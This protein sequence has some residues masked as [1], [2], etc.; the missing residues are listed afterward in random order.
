MPDGEVAS[1]RWTPVGDNGLIAAGA[2]EADAP[3]GYRLLS[4]HDPAEPSPNFVD[5]DN[6]YIFP[7][8][9]AVFVKVD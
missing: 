6:T 4:F 7:V 5:Y 3:P 2:A 9:S 8:T 1:G